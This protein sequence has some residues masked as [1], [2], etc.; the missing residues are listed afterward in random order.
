M[1]IDFILHF[2]PFFDFFYKNDFCIIFFYTFA[3]PF[4][5]PTYRGVEQW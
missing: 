5:E 3:V 1:N 4:M 2:C